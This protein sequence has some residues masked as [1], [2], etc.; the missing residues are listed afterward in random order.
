[1]CEFTPSWVI[2]DVISEKVNLERWA[3]KNVVHMLENG[4]TIPFIARY[5]KEQTGALEVDKLREIKTQTEELKGVQQKIF[6]VLTGLQKQ[7]K[8]TEHIKRSIRNAESLTEIEDLYAP[9]KPG[10]KGTLAER[11]RALNLESIANDCIYNPRRVD[12]KRCI[13]KD[14]KGLSSEKE[15][16]TGIQHIIADIINRDDSVIKPI[17]DL[18][19]ANGVSIECSKFVVSKKLGAKTLEKAEKAQ[20]TSYKFENYFDF[21]GTSKTIKPHQVLAIN[22]GEEQKILTV[23]YT[24][25]DNI[26]HRFDS[27][28]ERKYIRYDCNEAV[29]SLIRKAIEDCWN[30]LV[31]PQIIRQIR[32]ELTKFSQKSSI[33][34]F[35]SNLRNLL[36]SAPLKGHSILGIDPGFK[37]GCKCAV[38]SQTGQVLHTDVVYLYMSQ[39]MKRKLGQATERYGC[40]YIALGNGTAC[41]E[42]E[43]ILT[44]VVHKTSTKYCIVNEDGASIYSCSE[45]AQAEL[46]NLDP[47]LRGAVSIARRLLDPLAEL[48]KIDPKHIG[49]GQYQHDI[50]ESQLKA[51]LDSVVEECVSFVGVDLNTGSEALLRRVAGLNL[52]KAKSL[53]ERREKMGPFTNRSQLKFVKGLGDKSFQ[54][55]AG[56]LRISQSTYVVD[57]ES[58]NHSDVSSIP[59][60]SQNGSEDPILIS[61][62]EETSK[63]KKRK[64]TNAKVP[65]KV[66][67]RRTSWDLEPLDQTWIHPES[68]DAAQKLE[69]Q[70]GIKSSDIGQ[71]HC[72]KRVKEYQK[73]HSIKEINQDL[74]IGEPTLQLILDAFVQPC[75]YDIREKHTKPLFKEGIRDIASLKEGT[76]LTG[77]VTNVTHFGAFVDIGVGRDGLIHNSNMRRTE[78]QLG[79]RVE[80]RVI[81]IDRTTNRIGL[82]LEQKL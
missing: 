30:R 28:V 29:R 67:K 16:Q 27:S 46:P 23:K 76:A 74:K 64:A 50:P 57:V 73:K 22:R 13:K 70:I 45:L 51:A 61:D 35:S 11:A 41:R 20:Q 32:S 75:G 12:I 43:K 24:I 59:P 78:L 81:S 26:R 54:Q 34:V 6:T 39:E 25:P 63:G 17:K 68:Y 10:N 15:V 3:V 82:S 42:T 79:Y 4:A 31:Q 77:K 7:N 40:K 21:K 18:C 52:S 2:E 8:L 60:M 1:M 71:D 53:I 5:R 14:V 19:K 33:D 65:S 9:Y 66:K 72:I 80:V 44:E 37:N 47:T 49:V 36:L 38:I 62:E 58:M 48:V 69:E 56:F 55:C